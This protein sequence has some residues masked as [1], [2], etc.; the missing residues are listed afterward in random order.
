MVRRMRLPVRWRDV[1]AFVVRNDNVSAEYLDD[2]PNPS[3][4]LAREVRA[5]L[6]LPRVRRAAAIIVRALRAG[7]R[8]AAS[9]DNHKLGAT[10]PL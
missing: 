5:R 2:F 6:T 9:V 4:Q 10:Q 7:L 1:R 3:A 8:E